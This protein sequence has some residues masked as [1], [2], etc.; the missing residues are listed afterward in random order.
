MEFHVLKVR[1]VWG[2]RFCL[3]FWPHQTQRVTFVSILPVNCLATKVVKENKYFS[4][5]G[6][7]TFTYGAL[8][9]N[10]SDSVK[11]SFV[12]FPR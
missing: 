1:A 4:V 10:Y 11:T 2:T 9:C 6:G 7:F 12:D 8:C 5:V 3:Y